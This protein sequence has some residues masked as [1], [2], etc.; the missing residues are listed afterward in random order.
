[1]SADEPAGFAWA[2]CFCEENAWHLCQDPRLRR[3]DWSPPPED[4]RVLLVTNARR[5]VAVWRQR[6]GDPVVWD[7][8]ALVL[9]RVAPGGAWEAWD[10]DSTLPLPCPLPDWLSAS[11]LPAPPVLAPRFRLLGAAEYLAVFS[12]DRSHMLD[13]AGRPRAPFPPWPA[14]TR[15]GGSTLA[16][17]L[18]LGRPAPGEVLDLPGLLARCPG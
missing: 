2:A 6:A 5:S 1:M 14:I 13:P 7:Y 3:G 16:R 4:R 15:P 8:H 10:L 18:D 9:A 11:F 17:L 12:S